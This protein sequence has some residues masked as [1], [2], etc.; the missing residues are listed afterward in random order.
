MATAQDVR[1][2]IGRLREKFI[3]FR[4]ALLAKIADLQ[5]QIAAGKKPDVDLDGILAE[6]ESLEALLALDATVPPGETEV[7][8]VPPS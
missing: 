2:A 7:P 4:D 1:D 5:A 3:A 8:T 6:L